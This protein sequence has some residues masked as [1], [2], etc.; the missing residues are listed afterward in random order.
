MLRRTVILWAV[1][2]FLTS[3]HYITFGFSAASLIVFECTVEQF[4]ER[5]PGACA[6]QAPEIL[7]SR[8]LPRRQLERKRKADESTE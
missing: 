7:W 4:Q 8:V 2:G 5:S 3:V 6:A 1:T